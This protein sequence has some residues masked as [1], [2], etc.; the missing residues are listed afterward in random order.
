MCSHN[1]VQRAHTTTLHQQL[2]H[3]GRSSSRCSASTARTSSEF[4]HLLLQLQQRLPHLLVFFLL[5]CKL[6]LC[7]IVFVDEEIK[8][9]VVVHDS[10]SSVMNSSTMHGYR[11]AYLTTTL[12]AAI[13]NQWLG[14]R[15]SSC[16]H[17]SGKVRRQC[18]DEMQSKR[19]TALITIRLR[20][21]V[22]ILAE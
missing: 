4:M 12:M 5:G 10:L 20:R 1:A 15:R 22:L 6:L 7:L 2:Q 11:I 16:S 9:L 8:P 17:V 19:K 3:Y 13:G 21:N 18:S 14:I